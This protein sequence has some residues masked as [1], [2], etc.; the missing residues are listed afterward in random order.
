VGTE[1]VCFEEEKDLLRSWRNFIEEL[2][3][4]IITGYN[5]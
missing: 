5:T 4:D 2:D 3:P 1:V